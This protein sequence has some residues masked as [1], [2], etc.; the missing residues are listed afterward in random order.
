MIIYTF[1]KLLLN[2]SNLFLHLE[3]TFQIELSLRAR[4]V[5]LPVWQPLPGYITERFTWDTVSN[6]YL[7]WLREGSCIT[8]CSGIPQL[9]CLIPASSHHDIHFWAI[10]NTSDRCIMATNKVFCKKIQLMVTSLAPQAVSI[11]TFFK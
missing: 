8:R 4:L 11:K 5:W 2:F 7:F 1:E 6:A 3:V 9:N 10:L